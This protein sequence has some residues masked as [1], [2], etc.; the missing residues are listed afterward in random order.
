METKL[1]SPAFL[2]P[3]SARDVCV[4][5]KEVLDIDENLCD[6]H[7]PNPFFES[8]RWF[9]SLRDSWDQWGPCTHMSL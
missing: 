2:M 7:F 4:C 1:L 8:G 9:P 6:R 3:L 5:Q